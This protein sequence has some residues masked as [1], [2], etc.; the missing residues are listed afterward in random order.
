MSTENISPTNDQKYICRLGNREDSCSA[1]G[2]ICVQYGSDESECDCR[3]IKDIYKTPSDNSR[4]VTEIDEFVDKVRQNID[5]VIF[6][7]NMAEKPL[8]KVAEFLEILVSEIEVPKAIRNENV[9]LTANKK[10]MKEI[11]L[12]LALEISQKKLES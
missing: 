8:S 5:T 12:C 9:S 11:M 3:C 4:E 2:Y 10:T 1:P 7:I 6:T